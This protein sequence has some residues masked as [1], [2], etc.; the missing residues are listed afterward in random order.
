MIA[1]EGVKKNETVRGQKLQKIRF[2]DEHL[3]GMLSKS[4]IQETLTVSLHEGLLAIKHLGWGH[5]SKGR[6][7]MM[8]VVMGDHS[9]QPG[10]GVLKINKVVRERMVVFEG[11]EHC[12]GMGIVVSGERARVTL[13]DAQLA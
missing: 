11:F 5:K 1:A 3:S 7:M 2:V 8:M 12:F 10:V 6:V 9:P 4:E 13:A